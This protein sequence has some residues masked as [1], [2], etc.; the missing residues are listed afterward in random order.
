MSIPETKQIILNHCEKYPEIQPLDIFKLLYQ[1]TF[2]CGH[3]VTSAEAAVDYIKKELTDTNTNSDVLDEKLDGSF[4]RVHL[5]Y[6]E[7]G[8]NA[9]TLGKLFYLS[10][11]IKGDGKEALEERLNVALTLADE[12]K[13][14]FSAQDFRTALVKWNNDG[15]PAVHHSEKFRKYYK[16]AYRVISNDY[17]PFLPVLAKIDSML[18]QGK[19][20]LA[21]EGGSASGKSTFGALLEKLYDCTL[22]HMDDFFLQPSQRTPERFSEIGGN[23]DRE[24]FLSEVLVPLSENKTVNYRR[25]DCSSQIILDGERVTPKLLT[26]TEGAYSMHPDLAGYY[27]LSV[28]LDVSENCQKERI[29]KR[30]TPEF[31]ARFFNEWIPME[32]RYFEETDIKNRCNITISIV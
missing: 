18:S 26:V 8:L 5:G 4:S 7:K 6:L 24:R 21:V 9:E 3:M 12:R 15:C 30:N 31:A 11:F 13:L 14:P 32:K 16:P 23:V 20:R 17:V 2:G 25:F 28:F 19:V 29:L 1:S 22:F 27:N 10:S